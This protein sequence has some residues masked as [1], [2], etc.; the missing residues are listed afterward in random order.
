MVERLREPE[1][2]RT[3]VWSLI[4]GELYFH[5]D[6]TCSNGKLIVNAKYFQLLVAVAVTA[7]SINLQP[8]TRKPFNF[9]SRTFPFSLSFGYILNAN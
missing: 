2:I 9:Y 5:F 7:K 4:W 3:Q 6:V 1:G 8:Q